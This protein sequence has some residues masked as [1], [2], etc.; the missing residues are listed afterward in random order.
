MVWVSYVF[1]GVERN[2]MDIYSLFIIAFCFLITLFVIYLLANDDFVLL[3][4]HMAVA[5][6]FDLAFI[7][8]LIGLFSARLG[9]VLLHFTM[10]FLNPLVFFIFPY[11]PG[12]SL[13]SGIIGAGLFIYFYSNMSKLPKERICDIF[14][15]AFLSVLP[16]GLFLLAL[17]GKKTPTF[18]LSTG[19]L[20]IVSII[21][22]VFIIRLFQKGSIK[23]GGVSF[24][25]LSLFSLISFLAEFILQKERFIFFFSKDQIILFILFIIFTVFFIRQEYFL[26]RKKLS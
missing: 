26:F 21:F 6:I 9:Y 15:V 2:N 13:G 18:L 5:N 14:S 19:I 25:S 17:I 1:Y 23:D 12:L 8:F 4:R 20:I 10:G 11:F 16:V 24:L 22:F 3:R 7:T